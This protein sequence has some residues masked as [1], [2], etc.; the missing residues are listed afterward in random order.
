M[1]HGATVAGFLDSKDSRAARQKGIIDDQ[2]RLISIIFHKCRNNNNKSN[3][4]HC[5]TAFK[6]RG[7]KLQPCCTDFVYTLLNYTNFAY[8]N[9]IPLTSWA[10]RAV[11]KQLARKQ[12]ILRKLRIFESTVLISVLQAL[13]LVHVLQCK[14]KPVQKSAD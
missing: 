9:R 10:G 12:H 4:S 1:E 14:S 5:R 2:I 6:N 3:M 8:T 11:L 7:Q 13:R